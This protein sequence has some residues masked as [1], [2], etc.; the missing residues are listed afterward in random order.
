[1]VC[2]H[3]AEAARRADNAAKKEQDQAATTEARGSRRHIET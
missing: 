1:M 2:T 3:T